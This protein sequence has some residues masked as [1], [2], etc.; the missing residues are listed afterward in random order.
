MS[1]ISS[2]TRAFTTQ[3]QVGDIYGFLPTELVNTQL[4]TI[5]SYP[6]YSLKANR[7]I[8]FNQLFRVVFGS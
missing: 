3:Q 4:S 2:K 1:F 8:A 7:F 5:G 6:K